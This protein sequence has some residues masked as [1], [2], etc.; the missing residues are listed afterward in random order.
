M[1]GWSYYLIKAS[2][3]LAKE[4]GACP[5]SNETKYS[6]GIMPIDTYKRE[7]D[8]LTGPPTYRFDWETLREEAKKY[9]IRNSTLMALMPAESSAQVS[10]STNG[11]E[12]PRSLVSVK[13]SKD[14]VL[15]QVVPE[16]R[17]L[18][19]KYDLLW[20]Q[21]SPEGYLKICAI[22]QKFID[23]CISV[24][25]SYNPRHYEGEQIPMSEMISHILM[26][27]KYGGKTLYY[28][29]TNDNAGEYEEAPLA[30]SEISE[31]DC[32]SCKI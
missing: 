14:G 22:M 9:G 7:V 3:D 15:K 2:V 21:K 25:T 10:N 5:K 31:E 1:E 19:N 17:K 29:N 30:A 24:N 8:E 27:Y 23:Q 4:K 18:K 32:E 12:P 26:H 6:Q 13:Q 16:V 28:F 20:D 11:I